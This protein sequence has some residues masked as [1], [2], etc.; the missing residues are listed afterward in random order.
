MGAITIRVSR[1]G[2]LIVVILTA[3]ILLQFLRTPPYPSAPIHGDALEPL[4]TSVDAA[5]SKICIVSA[6]SYG[7]PK[8]GGTAT[9]FWQLAATLKKITNQRIKWLSVNAR[10][11][12]NPDCDTADNSTDNEI[13]RLYQKNGLQLV[14]LCSNEVGG[15]GAALHVRVAGINVW[16][17]AWLTVAHWFL[18]NPTDC[19]VVY[20]HEWGGLASYLLSVRDARPDLFGPPSSPS[21]RIVVN[22][23]GGHFWASSAT[24]YRPT[25]ATSLEIEEAERFSVEHA[26]AVVFPSRHMQDYLQ[27][28]GWDVANGDR[29]IRVIPNIP[30]AHSLPK[31]ALRQSKQWTDWSTIVFYSRLED[32]KGLNIFLNVV[33]Q[34]SE[35]MPKKTYRV[36]LLGGFGLVDGVPADHWLQSQLDLIRWPVEIHNKSSQLQA[37]DT[38]RKPGT[39]VVVPSLIENQPYV[40]VECAIFGLPTILFNTGGIEEMLEPS[41]ANQVAIEPTYDALYNRLRKWLQTGLGY[42]PVL[43][44]ELLTAQ[45]TWIRFNQEF[46]GKPASRATISKKSIA[47]FELQSGSLDAVKVRMKVC[48]QEVGTLH[49]RADI[50]II[51]PHG[52]MPLNDPET[53]KRVQTALRMLFRKEE[54]SDDDDDEDTGEWGK[55][56]KPVG[57]VILGT[58][59]TATGQTLMPMSPFWVGRLESAMCA[60]QY[61]VAVDRRLFCTHYTAEARTFSRFETW[62]IPVLMEQNGL[63]VIPLPMAAFHYSAAMEEKLTGDD[64]ARAWRQCDSNRNPLQKLIPPRLLLNLRGE[65]FQQYGETGDKLIWPLYSADFSSVQGVFSSL[66]SKIL[67]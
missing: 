58:H 22:V 30:P 60:Y 28:R 50:V 67:F 11:P 52:F 63:G 49:G 33:R 1:V 59:L 29:D 2:A 10:N 56:Q 57:A 34:L 9:A 5:N 3:F 62:Q 46:S 16:Q 66:R 61:P 48:S 18:A 42:A 19:N 38:I 55:T 20:V 31:K 21:L 26:D 15:R 51:V 8:M 32:R 36:V 23:H 54:I 65:A 25:D 4:L 43:R 24:L 6:D 53:T 39:L 41:S 17:T 14:C 13:F 47:L 7:F 40:V 37:W 27:Q 44:P 64:E 35:D 45:D 12:L